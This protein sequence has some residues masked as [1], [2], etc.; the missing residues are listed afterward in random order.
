[1]IQLHNVSL[2]YQNDMAALNNVSLKVPKGDFIFLTGQS[3]LVNR[4]F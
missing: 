2:A 4:P 3:G 1:M